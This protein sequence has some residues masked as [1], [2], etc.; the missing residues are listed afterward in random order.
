VG[1]DRRDK[2]RVQWL[3]PAFERLPEQRDLL[4]QLAS[5]E[6]GEQLGVGGA[7]AERVKHRPTR[8]SKD[9]GRDAVELDPRVLERLVQPVGL[10]LALLHLRLAVAGQLPQRPD[11]LRRHEA[12]SE[13]PGLEQLAQPLGVLDV[14]LPPR[15]VLHTPRVHE[16]QLEVILEHR[17]HGLP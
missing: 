10:A 14:G 7:V 12:C 9:V 17:P 1:E 8:D 11:R 5:G 16:Q 6:V 13:Q 4:A 3:E 15:D 2:Q